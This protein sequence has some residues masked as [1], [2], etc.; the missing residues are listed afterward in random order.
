MRFQCLPFELRALPY[1]TAERRPEATAAV[2]GPFQYGVGF[3]ARNLSTQT[4]LGPILG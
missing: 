2:L 1:V 4:R 3:G